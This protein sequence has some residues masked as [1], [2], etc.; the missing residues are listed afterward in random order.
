M[1]QRSIEL[2]ATKKQNSFAGAMEDYAANQP[3]HILW[4]AG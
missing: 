3:A 1:R 2:T 4:L